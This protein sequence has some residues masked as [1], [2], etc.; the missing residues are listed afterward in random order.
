MVMTSL[1]TALTII[2]HTHVHTHTHIHI[3]TYPLTWVIP[4]LA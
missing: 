1:L 2:T 4:E 3:H